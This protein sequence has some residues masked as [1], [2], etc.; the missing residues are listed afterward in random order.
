MNVS[1]KMKCRLPV[2]VLFILFVAI[3]PVTADA[4]ENGLTPA[5]YARAERFLNWSTDEKILG[6][7][8]TPEWIDENSFWYR[9]RFSDGYEFII[10]DPGAGIRER[11]F[12]HARLAGVLSEKR[13]LTYKPF[14]LPFTTITF[15]DD[16]RSVEFQIDGEAWRCDLTDYTCERSLQ[17]SQIPSD[18]VASPDGGKTA[19]IREHNLWM[20]VTGTGEEIQLTTDGEE[21]YGYATDSQGWSRSNRPILLWSPDSRMIVTYQLD[22]RG[23]EKMHLVEMAEGRPGFRSW[24]YALPGDSIVPMHERVVIHVD[25]PRV[26]RL[27]T[28]PDHQRTSS[29]CGLTREGVWADVEWSPDGRHLAFVST[30]RDY[31][32]VSLRIADPSTGTVSTVFEE[33]V[34]TFFESNLS[35]RGIP[36]WRVD[37]ENGEFIWFSRRDGWGHLYLYDLATGELKNRITS[38]AWNVLDLLRVDT[39]NRLIYFTA[40]GR[41]PGRDPY[42]AH[43]YRVRFNGADPE[44]LSPQDANHTVTIGPS[45]EYFVDAYS[46]YDVPPVSVVR[47]ADGSEVMRLETADITALEEIGWE[48]PIPFTAKGRDGVTDVYGLMFR[49]SDFDPGKSYPIINSIYPGPQRGSIDTRSFSTTGRGQ[50]K[51][52]AELGFIVV[53]VDAFGTPLRSESFHTEWYGT[54]G[55]N[56]LED[57]VAAMRELAARYEWIDLN[58]VGIYGH[59][60]GG[61][62]TVSALLRYPEFFHVGVSSAGNHD[63]RGYTYYWGEKYQGLLDRF[64]DGNDSY[65]NQANHLLA[66]NLKGK[67]LLTYGTMDPNVHPNLTLLLINELIKHDKDFDVMVYPNR[68][69]GYFNEPYNVRL[70]WNY[71]VRHLLG[72]EPPAEYRIVR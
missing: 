59:S 53:Q 12:D 31:K 28:G 11:A 63:N 57:Q 14:N 13:D 36:N 66:D 42:Y 8:V 70:T 72:K 19:F 3:Y 58:R 56:G 15:R 1:L 30:S 5:D 67:L 4:I 33:T 21:Y 69:H 10:V 52:L 17:Q 24:P 29:C 55:D 26:V 23:V 20:H 18:G 71:F 9:N 49:P 68:T 32:T 54:M 61:Y 38:G 47:R 45:G 41:E 51:A 6:G 7:E 65:T 16:R 64:D 43:L 46:R 34:E 40:V 25:E 2:V 39:E 44:L 50:T 27:D 35:S 62:A 48:P 60:G 37:H 22:E